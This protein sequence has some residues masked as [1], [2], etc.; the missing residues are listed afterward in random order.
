MLMKTLGKV[1]QTEAVSKILQNEA[2]M[3][4]ILKAV[5]VSLEAKDVLGEQYEQTLRTLSLAPLSRVEELGQQLD[6]LEA[7]ANSLKKQLLHLATTQ[8][9]QKSSESIVKELQ[10]ALQQAHTRVQSLETSNQKLQ[11]DNQKLQAELAE[12]KKQ[13]QAS[14]KTDGKKSST[15]TSVK[16]TN[17]KTTQVKKN[18]PKVSSANTKQWN[19]KMKKGDLL[20]IAQSLGLKANQ[21]HKKNEILMMLEQSK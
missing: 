15:K 12:L 8:Q 16:K 14:S 5:S 2:L 10:G 13:A 21:S 19:R 3:N 4:Q 18:S 11:A 6:M 9:N 17:S 1:V 7:E 20:L